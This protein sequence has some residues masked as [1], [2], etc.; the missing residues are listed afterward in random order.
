MLTRRRLLL[1]SLAS[2]LALAADSPQLLVCG[3][4]EVFA[5]APF[6]AEPTNKLWSWKAAG[7]P[8]LPEEYHD[9]FRTTDDCKPVDGGERVLITSSSNGVALV[10]RP[11]GKVLF[12]A[13]ARN[14][15]SAEMLPA[16]RIAVAA[17][18]GDTG[19]RLILFDSR[20]PAEELFSTELYSGHGVVWDAEREILWALG[21]REL[22]EY[23]L[24]EWESTKPSL[25]LLH[26][27]ELPTPGGHDLQPAEGDW[28]N[29]SS[30]ERCY[31]FDRAARRFEPHPDLADLE[32]V[33]C[34]SRH[35][36][37]GRTVYTQG[38]G[39]EWWTP[40]L[41]FLDP[42]GSLDLP[43]ERIYKARWIV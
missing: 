4:D 8:D 36:R 12:Y 31:R 34:I 23:G 41:R 28:L 13:Q 1:A 19:N 42:A 14:A 17:S 27:H 16:G 11:S 26:S 9:K 29:L 5:I 30:G 18:T 32:H 2:P 6:S 10:E 39:R 37:T 38:Q 20:R 22:R 21:G 40:T 43:G 15:H 24:R 3:W 35:P 33:K 7:R 25:E